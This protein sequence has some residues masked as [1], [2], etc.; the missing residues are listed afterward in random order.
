MTGR[1][2]GE[3][4]RGRRR[5]RDGKRAVL[6]LVPDEALEFGIAFVARVGWGR[7]AAVL[8]RSVRGE[9]FPPAGKGIEAD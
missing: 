8:K 7:S 9:F 4:W 5:G 6:V 1:V 3:S 2:R